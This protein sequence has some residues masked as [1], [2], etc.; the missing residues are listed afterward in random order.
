MGKWEAFKDFLSSLDCELHSD[1]I[2]LTKGEQT[3][4]YHLSKFDWICLKDKKQ[5]HEEICMY[6]QEWIN[7]L[8][9]PRDM[10]LND[11]LT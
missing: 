5:E 10:I 1:A 3:A 11:G 8:G 6:V 9:L 7:M 4:C 2:L